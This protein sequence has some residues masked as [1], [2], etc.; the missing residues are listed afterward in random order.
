[1]NVIGL[2]ELRG[3]VHVKQRAAR[4]DQLEFGS[5]ISIWQAILKPRKMFV[6]ALLSVTWWH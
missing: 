3:V 1:M 5:S 4:Q 6:I 2:E